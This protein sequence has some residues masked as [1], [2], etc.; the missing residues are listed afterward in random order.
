MP[1]YNNKAFNLT[2]SEIRWAM[3]NTTT[4]KAAAAFLKVQLIT[5]KRYAEM[6]WDRESGLNLYKLHAVNKQKLPKGHVNLGYSS[7]NC[8]IQE[9]LDGKHPNYRIDKLQNRLIVEGVLLEQC[10]ICGFRDRRITDY[11]I[12]IKLTFKNG[13]SKDHRLDNMEMVCYNCFYLY[14][15]ELLGK[16]YRIQVGLYKGE[17]KLFK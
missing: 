5:Y 4:N 6:Y 7:R 9:I 10:N 8:P 11:T 3:Q 14:Y 1:R 2:E 15:G 17:R 12:P 13:N 16:K